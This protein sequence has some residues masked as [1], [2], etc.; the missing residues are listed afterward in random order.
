MFLLTYPELIRQGLE[1][2]KNGLQVT[3]LKERKARDIVELVNRA[4]AEP[5]AKIGWIQDK[6]VQLPWQ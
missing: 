3:G 4:A 1:L 6:H 2:T 5:G